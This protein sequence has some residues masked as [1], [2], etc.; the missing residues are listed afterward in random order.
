MLLRQNKLQVVA[1]FLLHCSIR[2][3]CTI[4]C[5]ELFVLLFAIIIQQF[6]AHGLSLP[7][8][9]SLSPP[10][11]CVCLSASLCLS[12]S[13]LFRVLFFFSISDS[14]DTQMLVALMIAS[15]VYANHCF[16]S[17]CIYVYMIVCVCDCVC[18]PSPALSPTDPV[19]RG[20]LTL[21]PGAY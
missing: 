6:C 17:I 13:L 3:I 18:V 4:I 20:L 2:A 10:P 19:P 12:V 8:S 21:R 14:S 9:L 16:L 11:L 1:T 7:F 5:F 15:F